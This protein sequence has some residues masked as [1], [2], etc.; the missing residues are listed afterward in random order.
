MEKDIN[1]KT[2]KEIEKIAK[3]LYPEVSF[4][5][6][7]ESEDTFRA[8]EIRRIQRAAFVEGFNYAKEVFLSNIKSWT[9]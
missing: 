7:V 8:N 3:D 5:K 1:M 6:D 2:A 9:R 4:K